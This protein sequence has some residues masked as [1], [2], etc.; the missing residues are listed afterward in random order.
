ML[1]P[2]STLA[3]T[4][5]TLRDALQRFSQA[6]TDQQASW[7]KAYTDALAKATSSDGRVVVP[8]VDA[9]PLSTMMESLLNQGQSGA[10][11]GLLLRTRGFYQVDFTKPLLFL[12]EH[13]LP[14]RAEKLGMLPTEWGMMNETGNYPGQ[15]WL[16][17]Y[18]LWYQIPPYNTSP[19][20]DAL[21][22]VTMAVLT[23]LLVVF[24]F[25]PYVNRLPFHLGIHRLIWREY[26]RDRE[27]PRTP[28]PAVRR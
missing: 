14:A 9:G 10:L 13:T 20:G 16:W 23:L 11:D 3:D 18:T 28:P 2:L 12:S 22:W 7:E 25:I 26:Y 27:R 19:N 17:L 8:S 5:P 24:P 1:E 15:A 21:V 4:D 6:S